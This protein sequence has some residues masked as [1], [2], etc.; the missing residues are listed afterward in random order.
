MIG[1]AIRGFISIIV[2]FFM[3]FAGG[4]IFAMFF[5]WFWIALILA[6]IWLFGVCFLS[7]V[8]DLWF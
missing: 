3:I 5:Y 2:L 6:L 4:V 8:W 7:E 1:D